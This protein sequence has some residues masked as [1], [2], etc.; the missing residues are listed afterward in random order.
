MA[1]RLSRD[2][3][4]NGSVLEEVEFELK[5]GTVLIRAL[6]RDE[7]LRITAKKDMSTQDRERHMLVAAM[8]DPP[9]DWRD[10]CAWQERAHAGDMER[11]T[12]EIARISGLLPEQAKEE[13]VRFPGESD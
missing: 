4:L 13:T 12:T 11:L 7:A 2:D 9:M 6:S 10:V 8:V 3:L 1:E 5:N